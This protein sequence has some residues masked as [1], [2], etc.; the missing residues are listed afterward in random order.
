MIEK[1][2]LKELEQSITGKQKE[3]EEVKAK[4]AAAAGN[5]A[6]MVILDKRIA[7]LQKTL[8]ALERTKQA[9]TYMP[10]APTDGQEIVSRLDKYLDAKREKVQKVQDSLLQTQR[11]IRET[12]DFLARATETGDIDGTVTNSKKLDEL[13]ERL[14][15]VQQ[16]KERTE[17]LRTFPDGAIWEEWEKVCEEKREDWNALLQRIRMLADEYR[18][19][20]NEL[21]VMNNTMRDARRQMAQI[22]KENDALTF[23]YP[24]LTVGLDPE[25]LTI[26]RAD[27]LKPGNIMHTGFGEN[28]L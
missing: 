13:K 14:K 28:P 7:E 12:E 5:P 6:E 26:S 16:M 27:G 22:G 25:P 3:M 17:A 15:Y 9:V 1:S 4:R 11:E 20:C 10:P 8:A 2:R 18:S 21:V 23:F 19:A 24:I